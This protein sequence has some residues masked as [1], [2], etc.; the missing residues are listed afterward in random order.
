M[1]EPPRASLRAGL[2]LVFAFVALLEIVSL[3]QGVRSVRRLQARVIAD[4]GQRVPEARRLLGPALSAA[5]GG[6]WSNAASL[7]S[8]LLGVTELAVIDRAG[9]VLFSRPRLDSVAD[10][11]QPEQRARLARREPLVLVGRQDGTARVVTYLPVAEAASR[12]T[13]RL[14]RPVPDLD[15]EMREQQQSFFGHLV[16]LTAL[17]VASLLVLRGERA[18]PA[19]PASALQAYEQAMERLRDLGEQVEA[20][21]EAERRLMEDAIREK[22]AMARAGELTAGIVHEVR[23]GL[24]TIVGYARMLEGSGLPEDPTVAAR[25]IREEAEALEAV[26]RRFTDLIRL[27]ELRLGPTDLKPLLDRVIAR[28][29]RGHDR[30]RVCLRP[31]EPPFLIQADEEMLERALENLVR[32]A[33]TAAEAGGGTVEIRVERGEHELELL[34]EDDGPGL[35]PDYPGEIRPFYST[36]PGGLGLGLPLARKVVLLHGGVLRLEPRDP[37]GARVTVVLP[38]TAA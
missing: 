25:S 33:V 17:A 38:L 4:A 20:R 26:I 13:L 21:H 24:G 1:A 37:R 36:S 10:E 11:L 27:E 29:G 12:P 18:A 19:E 30:V 15:Q 7:A 28:E 2:A 9:R 31:L 16:S 14:A 22:D 32:N 5:S 34:V 35:A 6:D 23:N 3:V 8:D